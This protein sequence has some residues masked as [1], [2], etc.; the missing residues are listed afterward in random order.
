[1]FCVNSVMYVVHVTL[2]NTHTIFNILKCKSKYTII[3]YSKIICAISS[4]NILI[5]NW[6]RVIINIHI[7]VKLSNGLIF[8]CK[9][10]SRK[11]CISANF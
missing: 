5:L 6:K 9:I 1:M 10:K 8:I 11:F 4:K 2:K 3:Y 7:V